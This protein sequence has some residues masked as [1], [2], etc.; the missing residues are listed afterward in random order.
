VS[1]STYI[2]DGFQIVEVD[3]D[4]NEIDPQKVDDSWTD[5]VG[6]TEDEVVVPFTRIFTFFDPDTKQN[7]TVSERSLY[8]LQ[9]HDIEEPSG[10]DWI[11]SQTLRKEPAASVI[12]FTTNPWASHDRDYANQRYEF[13]EPIA[14]PADRAGMGFMG[15]KA[16]AVAYPNSKPVCSECFIVRAANGSCFC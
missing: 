6:M 1:K 10:H 12:D 13:R 2:P 9:I 7:Y 3:A 5:I 16:E 11:G 15:N 8:L 4:G 14:D